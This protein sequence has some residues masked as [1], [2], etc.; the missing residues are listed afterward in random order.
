MF[1]KM[2]EFVGYLGMI[3]LILILFGII[4]ALIEHIYIKVKVFFL[5]RKLKKALENSIFNFALVSSE[6]ELKKEVEKEVK[7]SFKNNIK[8][9]E[10]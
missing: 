5:N 10:D 2:W 3:I 4:F 6:N 9:K 1:I 8:K 7:K